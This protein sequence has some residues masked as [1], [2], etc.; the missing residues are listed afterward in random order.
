MSKYSGCN[1]ALGGILMINPY[2][3]EDITRAID[4]AM[5]NNSLKS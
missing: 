3:V 5:K 2:N 1:P 4:A